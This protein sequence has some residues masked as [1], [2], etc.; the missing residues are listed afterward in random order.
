MR[1]QRNRNACRA[2]SLARCGVDAV[3]L[4]D[5]PDAAADGA[6]SLVVADR[7][8]DEIAEELQRFLGGGDAAEAA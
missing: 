6:P 5:C 2:P 1:R 8:T 3:Y 7:P 4:Q